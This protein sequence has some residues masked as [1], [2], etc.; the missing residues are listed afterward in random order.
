LTSTNGGR[1]LR[2]VISRRLLPA[3]A[4]LGLAAVLLV[5]GAGAAG[6]QDNGD[7]T[8]KPVPVAQPPA[9]PPAEAAP[10]AEAVNVRF[11]AIT[12]SDLPGVALFGT[13]LLAAGAGLLYLRRRTA[14]DES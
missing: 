9:S 2:H 11:L 8:S 7:Y 13:V 5:G 14:T 10:P 1:T 4:A 6:A 3:V 12:G